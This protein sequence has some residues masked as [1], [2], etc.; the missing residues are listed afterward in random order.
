MT[1]C[2]SKL[3]SPAKPG[4]NNNHIV[5]TAM[6]AESVS[7]DTAGDMSAPY[8]VPVED[9]SNVAMNCASYDESVNM[10]SCNMVSLLLTLFA[11]SDLL[12]VYFCLDV[13]FRQ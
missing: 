6:E 4:H 13:A 9:V 11:D 3:T 1:H 5:N 10:T 8:S 12:F 2:S 7:G